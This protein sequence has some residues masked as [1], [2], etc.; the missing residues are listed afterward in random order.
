MLL[1]YTY[2]SWNVTPSRAVDRYISWFFV[3][4]GQVENSGE[5]RCP[6]SKQSVCNSCKDVIVSIALVMEPPP[7]PV[8]VW[9]DTR[10]S[11]SD[12]VARSDSTKHS[13]EQPTGPPTLQPPATSS[14]VAAASCTPAPLGEFSW[15]H[16]YKIVWLFMQLP[17]FFKKMNGRL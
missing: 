12:V 4:C 10:A 1:Y 6:N 3:V 7:P 8:T 17:F 2:L 11:F 13:T 16:F 9:D 15:R 14:S 5:D